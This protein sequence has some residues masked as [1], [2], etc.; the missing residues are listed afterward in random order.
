[1][2]KFT[3]PEIEKMLDSLTIIYDTRERDTSEL[4]KRIEGFNRPSVRKALSYG[5]YSAQ[6]S[7]P[8]GEISDLT[9]IAVIER[10][11]NLTEICSNFT[12][13]RARFQR[14]FERAK[15]DNCKVHL[16]I[17]NDDYEH[18]RDGKYRSKLNP[19]SLIASL[20]SW[21]IRYGIMVHFCKPETT[22]YLISKIMHYSLREYLLSQ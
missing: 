22:G 13:E 17:E 6:Y 21:A 15:A 12:S 2:S 10:K 1:M 4:R 20:L 5:D 14:E 7:L 3:P 11:Q 9:K 18:L 8:D 16:I 19:D